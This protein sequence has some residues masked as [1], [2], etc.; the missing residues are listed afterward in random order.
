MKKRKRFQA[1]PGDEPGTFSKRIVAD[2]TGCY[3]SGM[4]IRISGGFLGGR[5]FQVPPGPVRPT[6]DRVRQAIFSSL[7]ARV[8]GA[9]VLDLFAGAGALGLEAFSRGADS[10]VWVE[11]HPRVAA[12]LKNNV[13]A[14]C[15]DAP[16][17]QV[18]R[19]DVWRFLAREGG[20]SFDLILADPPYASEGEDLK[21]LLSCLGSGVMLR[22]GG[23]LVMEQRAEALEPD[24]DGWTLI[25]NGV[26]G[27]TRI[28]IYRK[29]ATMSLNP[30]RNH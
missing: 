16:R 10:V 7:L 25:K 24:L 6:Q 28:C 4:S 2:F 5:R 13:R 9:A 18:V 15:G 17:L 1:Q 20:A 19:D 12:V 8:P 11:L 22:D 30:E 27:E 29:D 21:K 26:Y 3:S 14:L 23:C